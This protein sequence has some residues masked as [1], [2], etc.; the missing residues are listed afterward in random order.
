MMI[1]V[2]SLNFPSFGKSKKL[3]QVLE[4]GCLD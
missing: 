4:I 3:K 2:T 1:G